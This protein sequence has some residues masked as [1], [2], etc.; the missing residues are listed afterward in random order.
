M[1]AGLL[2]AITADVVAPALWLPIMRA[3][4][5][6]RRRDHV[7]GALHDPIR[8]QGAALLARAA[9]VEEH[10]YGPATGALLGPKALG[11]VVIEGHSA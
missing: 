6:G 3:I 2:A 7:Q 5:D 8:R 4:R 10:I 9:A 11:V 1:S